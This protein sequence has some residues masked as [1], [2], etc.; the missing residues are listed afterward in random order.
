MFIFQQSVFI[1]VTGLAEEKTKK[2]KFLEH[3]SDIYV[4]AYGKNLE[5]AFENVAFAM[6]ESMTDL[7]SVEQKIK[8]EVN[9]EGEDEESLLY[10]WLEKLLVKFEVDNFL[11]SRFKVYE[12]KQVN[13]MFKLRAEV[14]GE[15]YNPEKHVSKVGIKAVT[16][17]GMEI[18][19]ENGKF[20]VKVL[21]DI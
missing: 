15:Q 8:F 1:G 19:K 2:F 16:Y 5:E 18:K 17:H 14:W 12:I 7:S 11:F 4:V 20:S 10:N 9:V 13:N 6:F 3:V 21:F